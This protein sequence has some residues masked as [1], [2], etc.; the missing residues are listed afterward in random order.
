MRF[1]KFPRTK[2]KKGDFELIQKKK[3]KK[4]NPLLKEGVAALHVCS[5]QQNRWPINRFDLICCCFKSI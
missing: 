5:E 4:E 3:K 1:E 2:E